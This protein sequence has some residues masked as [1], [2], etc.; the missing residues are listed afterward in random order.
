MEQSLIT[1]AL[2]SSLY[3]SPK[4]QLSARETPQGN[5]STEDP[6]PSYKDAAQEACFYHLNL[7]LSRPAQMNSMWG[8]Q[9][10][11]K[12]NAIYTDDRLQTPE[13]SRRTCYLYS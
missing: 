5:E 10:L 4:G 6:S 13:K 12:D 1:K 3:L 7:K 11:G 2:N 8:S 9:D